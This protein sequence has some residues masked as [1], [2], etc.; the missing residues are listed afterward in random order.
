MGGTIVRL[1]IDVPE[2]SIAAV[3]TDERKILYCLPAVG[4]VFGTLHGKPDTARWTPKEVSFA[5]G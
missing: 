2:I 4:G 5:V 1:G 3:L